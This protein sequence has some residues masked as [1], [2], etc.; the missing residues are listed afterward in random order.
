MYDHLPAAGAILTISDKTVA[1][2][3]AAVT[4]SNRSAVAFHL[5]LTT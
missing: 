5:L 1:G 2:I 3:L 4:E